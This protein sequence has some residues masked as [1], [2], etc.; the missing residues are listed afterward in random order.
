[1]PV[2]TEEELV[3]RILAMCATIQ[4]KP[5]NLRGCAATWCITG[6]PATSVI[7]TAKKSFELI[8]NN[9]VK[10]DSVKGVPK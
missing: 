3:A 4:T 5:G 2:E 1:M 7:A 8:E 6:M 9:A 10:S